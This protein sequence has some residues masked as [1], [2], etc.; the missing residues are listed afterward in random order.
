MKL[1]YKNLT[2]VATVGLLIFGLAGLAAVSMIGMFAADQFFSGTI[3]T[4]IFGYTYF[5]SL[6]AAGVLLV[7]VLPAV[8][9]MTIFDKA[10]G[11]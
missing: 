9:I 8:V 2:I 1:I 7:F 3:L 4:T 10:R 5:Y 6:F 11:R